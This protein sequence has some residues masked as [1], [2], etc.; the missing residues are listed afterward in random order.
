MASDDADATR[1]PVGASIGIFV[2]LAGVACAMT[3]LFLGMRSV[4]DIGGFCAE[5]G[6]YV[7]GV[8][9]PRGVSAIMIGGIWAGLAFAGL[10]AWLAFKH[11]VPNF[12]ALLWSGLFLSLGWNF[13]VYGLDAPGDAG[14]A[15]GWLVCAVLFLLMGGLPLIL[16]LPWVVRGFTGKAAPRGVMG[17]GVRSAVSGLSASRRRATAEPATPDPSESWSWEHPAPA[18]GGNQDVVSRLER[19]DALHRSGAL[20]DSEYETAKNQILGKGVS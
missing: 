3:L 2:G 15:W 16:V 18:E 19:L 5:G 12:V 14:L 20:D 10:Y 17:A 13:L 9:C 4:M 8:S 1:I 11:G 7:I 6:P